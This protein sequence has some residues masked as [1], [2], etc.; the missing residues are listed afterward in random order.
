VVTLLVPVGVVEDLEVVEVEHE[1]A[2]GLAAPLGGGQE[3]VQVG[4]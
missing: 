1:H 4:V 2:H 3:P